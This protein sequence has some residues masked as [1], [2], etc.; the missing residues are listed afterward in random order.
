[1]WNNPRWATAAEAALG[2]E[3]GARNNKGDKTCSNANVKKKKFK[4]F[5]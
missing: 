4:K 3:F 5:G 1:M 2:H